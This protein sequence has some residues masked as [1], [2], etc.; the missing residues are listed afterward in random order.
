MDEI[1]KI[2]GRN[3]KLYEYYGAP[4]ATE[5]AVAMGSGTET[6][7]EVVDELNSHGRKVGM[8][9]V[10]LFRPFSAKHFLSVLPETVKKVAVLD[11][12]K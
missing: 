7:R 5:V 8:I 3:Y 9:S 11:R 4:D 2:T 1:N 6:L 10:H 12:T